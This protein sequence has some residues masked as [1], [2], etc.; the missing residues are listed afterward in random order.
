MMY[1]VDSYYTK[2]LKTNIEVDL[3]IGAIWKKFNLMSQLTFSSK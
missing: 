1:S 2:I 3:L